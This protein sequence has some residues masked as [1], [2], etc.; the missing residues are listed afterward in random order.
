LNLSKS[1]I[2]PPAEERRNH[3]NLSF[4]SLQSSFFTKV[5]SQDRYI[6]E[7]VIAMPNEKG[8]PL[9]SFC[10]AEEGMEYDD[11]SSSDDDDST[12]SNVSSHYPKN[13]KPNGGQS[14]LTQS[15]KDTQSADDDDQLGSKEKANVEEKKYCGFGLKYMIVFV[16]LF[17]AA[18]F[19]AGLMLG[20]AKSRDEG[21][22][23]DNALPTGKEEDSGI[24]QESHNDISRPND[25]PSPVR[26]TSSIQDD[27]EEK[28]ELESPIA[29][30]P[31]TPAR[32]QSG[33]PTANLRAP[34]APPSTYTP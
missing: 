25:V 20:V 6:A 1:Q 33:P 24:D 16:L 23:Q 27:T 15:T 32:T 8:L 5:S 2:S 4:A 19:M 34:S 22:R 7:F 12:F 14:T 17:M 21:L 30:S 26:P 9:S 29:S 31:T 18:S 10:F 13:N 28:D 11:A 3:R